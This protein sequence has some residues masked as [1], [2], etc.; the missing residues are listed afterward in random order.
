MALATKCPQCG[1]MFR[2][3]ADQLK[4]RGG[5]VRCGQ[6]RTVF[7]AI[8][9]LAYV[10]DAALTASRPMAESTRDPDDNSAAERSGPKTTTATPATAPAERARPA[11]ERRRDLSD[12]KR[13][14]LGPSTTLRIAPGLAP[15]YK[16]QHGYAQAF[17]EDIAAVHREA[18]G[19]LATRIPLVRL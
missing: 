5:L 19:I 16:F 9:S 14:A 12:R 18:A 3:V 17:A 7:D 4:L 15:V 10:E 13:K 11:P 6:C 2:V 8:G 1:A